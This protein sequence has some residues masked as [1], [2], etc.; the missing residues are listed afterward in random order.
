MA[1]G[2]AAVAHR[3]RAAGAGGVLRV[4]ERRLR[5]EGDVRQIDAV[6]REGAAGIGRHTAAIGDGRIGDL[7]RAAAAGGDDEVARRVVADHRDRRDLDT[8]R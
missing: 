5:A 6:L 8:P 1:G 7:H 3:Q 2:V 4:G